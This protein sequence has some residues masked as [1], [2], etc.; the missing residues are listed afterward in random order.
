MEIVFTALYLMHY[1][2]VLTNGFD[3]NCLDL[4]RKNN[5][6][7]SI[8]A[9]RYNVKKKASDVPAPIQ[10]VTNQTLLGGE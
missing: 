8:Q 9:K 6:L 1:V 2:S 7:L 5:V 10:D 3:I 4:V